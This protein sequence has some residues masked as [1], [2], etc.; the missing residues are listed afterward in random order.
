MSQIPVDIVESAY[1]DA[2]DAYWRTLAE[3]VC[4]RH[5]KSS[6]VRTDRLREQRENVVAME[7]NF[8]DL[9]NLRLKRESK[10][11]SIAAPVEGLNAGLLLPELTAKVVK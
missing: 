9:K 10:P 2:L 4:F 3:H 5:V 7:A 8:P 1:L 11:S 6:Q